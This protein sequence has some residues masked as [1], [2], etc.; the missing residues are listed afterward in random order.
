MKRITAIIVSLLICAVSAFSLVSADY[1]IDESGN[2][3]YDTAIG[4]CFDIDD[5]NGTITGEDATII[6]NNEAL[7]N[8]GSKWAIWFVASELDD[9]QI[10]KVIT[11]GAA[12]GGNIPTITLL[13]GE[14]FV[15]IHS[16]SSNP[17]DAEQYDNWEDKVAALAV[18]GGDCLAFDGIDL[19]AGTCVNGRMLVVTEEEVLAGLIEFPEAEESLPPVDP[20]IPS[21]PEVSTPV[22]E[23]STEDKTDGEAEQAP[24]T[25]KDDGSKSDTE[26]SVDD[27]IKTSVVKLNSW[28]DDW[29]W[30]VIIG[31]AVLVIA[32][33]ACVVLLINK[34]SK[35]NA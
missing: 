22:I 26:E 13:E 23:E 35:K 27:E 18:K 2:A 21:E 16:A 14:I 28:W 19:D 5:I 1:T 20:V 9:S 29:K 11:N 7:A 12:M 25:D 4:Y 34:K 30:V 8:I 32:A 24:E 3:V 15:A 33:V 17:N 31:G 10:Y 6:T